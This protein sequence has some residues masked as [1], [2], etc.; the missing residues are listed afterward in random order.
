MVQAKL[1]KACL[2]APAASGWLKD[3]RAAAVLHVFDRVVNLK[4]N[5][6]EII[7]VVAP[8]TATAGAHMGPFTLV[9]D[10]SLS[11]PFDRWIALDSP[12]RV[13]ADK[14]HIGPLSVA[15][16]GAAA[17]EP[18]PPWEGL[19]AA[20]VLKQQPLLAALVA[21]RASPTVSKLGADDVQ[22]AAELAALLAGRGPG[23]TP[24]GDDFVM[25]ML[26]ALWALRPDL[27]AATAHAIA[28]RAAARTTTLSAAW[29]RAAGRGEADATW[30]SLVQA[31]AGRGGVGA[32]A[33]RVMAVGHTS[34]ADALAGFVFGLRHA[35]VLFGQPLN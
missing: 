31:L 18:R 30:H 15:V 19:T 3:P 5:A 12:V 27:A 8:T 4:N 35:A 17:W 26:Y 28:A 7:A 10:S 25:G 11:A 1:L 16:G 34:G 9:L 23:L 14:L 2:I 32:A 20:E 6:D 21:G 33:G 22:P 29:L 24:S 13:T